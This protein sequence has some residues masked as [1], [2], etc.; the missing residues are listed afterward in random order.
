MT[1]LGWEDDQEQEVGAKCCLHRV[2]CFCAC[3][4]THVCGLC[5]VLSRHVRRWHHAVCIPPG[6]AAAGVD[7]AG[8]GGEPAARGGC[9]ATAT[10]CCPHHSCACHGLC[11]LGIARLSPPAFQPTSVIIIT[12]PIQAIALTPSSFHACVMLTCCTLVSALP[13]AGAAIP[14]AAWRCGRC[15]SARDRYSRVT[16]DSCRQALTQHPRQQ[17]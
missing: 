3:I 13:A 8:V 15:G 17:Q 7:I 6:T 1:Q 12:S 5:Y 10:Q 16:G 2:L 4:Y 14:G 11:F 9:C